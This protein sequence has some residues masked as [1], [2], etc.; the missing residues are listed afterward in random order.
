VTF[1]DSAMAAQLQLLWPNAHLVVPGVDAR[2]GDERFL[3]LPHLR[4]PKLLLPRRPR[5]TAGTAVRNYKTF[6]TGRDL[7]LLRLVSGALR[8]G[9][10][11]LHP[12]QVIVRPTRHPDHGQG[13][14]QGD[15]RAYLVATLGQDVR[16]SLHVGPDR[17]VRKPV[18][19]LLSSRGRTV[20]FAKLGV[21]DLTRRLVRS[22]AA[23]LREL[24]QLRWTC[25]VLPPVLH[26]GRWLD[27]EVLVLAP[28]QRAGRRRSAPGALPAAMVE[29][30]RC[31]GVRECALADSDYALR[32]RRR[33]DGVAGDLMGDAV[34]RTWE[35]VLEVAGNVPVRFG[36][37]HG[38]WAPWNM[39]VSQGRVLL[40][41]WEHFETGVPVGFDAVHHAVQAAVA[42]QGVAP[43]SAVATVSDDSRT[44]LAPFEVA[45][46]DAALTVLLYLLEIATRYVEDGEQRLDGT[47]MGR[48]G[49]WLQPT[50]ADQLLRVEREAGRMRVGD[51]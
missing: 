10:G 20:G 6:A 44:L 30:A 49:A 32:L 25:L 50:L 41:D 15:V 47:S 16:V 21:D 1:E 9:L 4:R 26:H 31:R 35:R 29:L 13:D 7:A 11:D 5:R 24:T 45:T 40:W 23:T 36:A 51:R 33:L 17:A 37:W 38:D 39:T 42:R 3:V 12:G 14:S 18:L 8:V 46:G 34:R 19:Q 43:R 48:L 2:P 22:E 27:H 28:L